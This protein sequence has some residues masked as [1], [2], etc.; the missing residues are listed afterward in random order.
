[1]V[2]SNE[3]VLLIM[4]QNIGVSASISP[5]NEY[6]GLI[7]YRMDWLDGITDLMCMSFSKL[8]QLVLDREVRHAA[9]VGS[10]RVRRD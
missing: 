4:G 8:Q 6:S 9:V 5:S 2:F 7:S 1:M 10:Q 3:S